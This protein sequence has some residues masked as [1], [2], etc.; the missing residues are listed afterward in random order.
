[1]GSTNVTGRAIDRYEVGEQLGQGGF[2]AVYRAR[3]QVLGTEVALKV[4]WPDRAD[5]P[6]NVARFLQEARAAAAIGSSHI[7]A[8]SDAGTAD[9]GQVFLA[10][11]LLDGCDLAEELR[12]RRALPID[13]AVGIVSE[14]L[15]GL[16]AAHA[17]GVIHRDLKPGNVFLAQTERGRRVKLLDFGISKVL[18]AKTLTAEGMM[19]GTPHYMAPEQLEG[20][21]SLDHRADLFA[22]GCILYEL[23]TSEVPFPGQSYQVILARVQGM[24]PADIR[25]KSPEVSDALADVIM[26]A[27]AVDPDARWPNARAMQAALRSAATEGPRRASSRLSLRTAVLD[28]APPRPS[29]TV[30]ASPEATA[31]TQAAAFSPPQARSSASAAPVAALT[32]LAV[33]LAGSLGVLGVLGYRLSVQPAAEPPGDAVI[34]PAVSRPTARTPSGLAPVPT[35]AVPTPAVPLNRPTAEPLAMGPAPVVRLSN[36]TGNG[37]RAELDALIERAIPGLRRCARDRPL[38]LVLMVIISG[39][40]VQTSIPHPLR[41][42]DNRD[43]AQCAAEAIRAADP[44]RYGVATSVTMD[45][46]IDLPAR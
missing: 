18:G 6:K 7:V 42:S 40:S 37:S 27:L 41:R 33:L 19:L 38:Q 10:M 8:V 22:V 36:V 12:A 13:E 44:L 1:M 26:R 24:R 31:T 21:R 25:A 35:P 29:T 20:R 45:V 5:D 43:D 4:L 30:S 32:V 16:A 46:E 28:S 23:I 17:A 2:G 39:A 3:H 14:I 11:E 34:D 9:D 15:E